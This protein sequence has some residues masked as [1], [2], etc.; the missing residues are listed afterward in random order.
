M[1]YAHRLLVLIYAHM[2][3]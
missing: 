3:F 2:F 1:H